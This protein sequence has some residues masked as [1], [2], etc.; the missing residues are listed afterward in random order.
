V[1]VTGQVSGGNLFWCCVGV[2]GTSMGHVESENAGGSGQV[3]RSGRDV[4]VARRGSSGLLQR[5]AATSG[6]DWRNKYSAV[7]HAV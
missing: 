2:G 6:V 3:T 7:W 1:L 5:N 4:A